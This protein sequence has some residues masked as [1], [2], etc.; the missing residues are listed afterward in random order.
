M[1]SSRKTQEKT[2]PALGL[3]L[4]LFSIK[5]GY[6]APRPVIGPECINDEAKLAFQLECWLFQLALVKQPYSCLLFG[7]I[8]KVDKG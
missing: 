5:C 8:E 4:S 2:Y 3:L 7:L 1:F 6:L